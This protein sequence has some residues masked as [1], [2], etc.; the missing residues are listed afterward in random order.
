MQWDQIDQRDSEPGL[1]EFMRRYST[2]S[3]PV[4]DVRITDGRVSGWVGRKSAASPVRQALPGIS[5]PRGSI[6]F[7]A[8]SS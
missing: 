6:D 2:S 5:T 8:S 7:T 3:V 1:G 4:G